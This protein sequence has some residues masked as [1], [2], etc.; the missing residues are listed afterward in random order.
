ME[1]AHGSNGREDNGLEFKLDVLLQ[2]TQQDVVVTDLC[3]RMG[4]PPSTYYEWRRKFLP[5]LMYGD[6]NRKIHRL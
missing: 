6:Y 1:N 4:V 2:G 5:S 3:Q